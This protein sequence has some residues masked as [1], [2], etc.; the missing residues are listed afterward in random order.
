MV[1]SGLKGLNIE[2]CQ[3]SLSNYTNMCNFQQLH[4]VGRGS[5]TQIKVGGNLKIR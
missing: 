4:V 2:I 1:N 3:Y 5:E